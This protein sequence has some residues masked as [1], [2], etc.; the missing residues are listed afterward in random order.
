MAPQPEAEPHVLS[1]CIATDVI[2]KV[3]FIDM[4]FNGP[5]RDYELTADDIYASQDSPEVKQGSTCSTKTSSQTCDPVDASLLAHAT[6]QLDA[7][8][9]CGVRGAYTCVCRVP[10]HA[11]METTA[12]LYVCLVFVPYA[13]RRD[14]RY[15]SRIASDDPVFKP[16]VATAGR[17]LGAALL[18]SRRLRAA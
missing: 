5:T 14:E 2:A 12:A 3:D 11:C 18:G 7:V 8:L 15:L 1:G 10:L 6:D 13:E 4:K 17:S 16:N 9:A